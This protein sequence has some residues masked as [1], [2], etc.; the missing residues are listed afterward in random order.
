MIYNLLRYSSVE[1]IFLRSEK[2]NLIKLIIFCNDTP[3][4]FIIKNNF[5]N[6]MIYLRCITFF[7]FFISMMQQM[8]ER[9]YDTNLMKIPIDVGLDISDQ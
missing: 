1:K 2:E 3:I 9:E 7:F 8:E 4:N 6:L 5:N